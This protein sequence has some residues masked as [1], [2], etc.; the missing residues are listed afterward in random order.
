VSEQNHD[1]LRRFHGQWNI[2]NKEMAK[3]KCAEGANCS[4]KIRLYS[5]VKRGKMVLSDKD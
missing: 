5:S 2:P 3:K 4:K 1:T